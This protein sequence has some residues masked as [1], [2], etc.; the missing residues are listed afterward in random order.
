MCPWAHLPTIINVFFYSKSNF[1]TMENNAKSKRK[2]EGFLKPK[3]VRKVER[4]AEE[5]CFRCFADGHLEHECQNPRLQ[6]KTIFPDT[7][8]CTVCLLPGHP[9]PLCPR[10]KA[11]CGRCEAEGH[12]EFDCVSPNIPR[13]AKLGEKVSS[14]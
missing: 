13:Y 5:V 4:E 7:V 9:G 14:R 3:Q 1:I 10:R 8:W 6:T 12:S 2:S 11:W